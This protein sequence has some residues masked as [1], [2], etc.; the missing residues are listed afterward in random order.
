MPFVSAFN[1]NQA[2]IANQQSG[3]FKPSTRHVG[4]KYFC[5]QD[6]VKNGEV[7]ISYVRMDEMIADGLTKGLE[8][9]KHHSFIQILSLTT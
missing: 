7:V 6:L 8:R 2:F 1:E 4:V 9:G 5:L 3:Q